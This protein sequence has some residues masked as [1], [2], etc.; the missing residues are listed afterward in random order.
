[1]V[2]GQATTNA[3]TQATDAFGYRSGQESV[4]IY[5]D[6]FVRALSLE[7]AGNYRIGGYYFVRSAGTNS[8]LVEAV[9][10]GVGRNTMVTDF[11]GPTGIVNITMREPSAS[12]ASQA[13]LHFNTY[14]RPQLEL[15]HNAVGSS[16]SGFIG[17]FTLNPDENDMQGGDGRSMLLGIA[18]RLQIG[19]RTAVRVFGVE[20]RYERN[21]AFRL[22]PAGP[23]LPARFERGRYLGQEWAKETGVNRLAGLIF[24]HRFDEHWSAGTAAYFSEGNPRKAYLHLFPGVDDRGNAQSRIIVSPEHRFDTWS[25]EGRLMWHGAVGDLEQRLS[26]NVRFRQSRAQRGGDALVELGPVNLHEHPTDVVRHDVFGPA[27]DRDAID[28]YGSGITYRAAWRERLAVSAGVLNTQYEKTTRRANAEQS[29]ASEPWLY[30]LGGTYN[31]TS[32][33]SL[34][35][36]YTRGLEDSGSAPQT[37]SNRNSVLPA[38]MATQREAGVRYAVLPKASLVVSAFDIRKP[39][40][41]L[42][43]DTGSYELIGAVR[44]TGIEGSLSGEIGPGLTAVIGGYVMSPKLSGVEISAGRTSSE[45][46]GVAKLRAIAALNYSLPIASDIALDMRM[47]HSGK[48]PARSNPRPGTLDSD[49]YIPSNST[50]DVGARYRFRLDG[51]RATLRVQ[52][53]NVF[54]DYSWIVNSAEAL[55]YTEPRRYRLA[56]TV[57]Y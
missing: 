5:D 8:P 42:R 27:L 13:T 7:A 1:M 34:Y 29:N 37:A 23:V 28:Q 19:E 51:K 35:G 10:V 14:E 53:L 31:L 52:V 40:A 26:A 15:V 43:R 46:V 38:I 36:S 30:N 25:G 33:F 6:Q 22:T 47:E 17:A 2:Y 16:G 50:L 56:F 41:G 39:Y 49:L 48:R 12:R 45:P 55:N 44:H 4:G 11:P 9:T 57:D 18:P 24:E 20:Y 3:V 54:D 32:K 21:A